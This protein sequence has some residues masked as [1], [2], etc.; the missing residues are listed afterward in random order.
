MHFF[1]KVCVAMI[2]RRCYLKTTLSN[3]AIVYG[4]NRS[5]YGGRGV[6]IFRDSIEPEFQHLE[7]FL[8]SSGVFIDVGASTGIYSLKAAKH[9][10]NIGIVI[11]IEPFPEVFATLYKSVVT[12]G[13]KNVRLRNL[14][15]W[16][17]TGLRTLWKNAH[18]PNSFSIVHRENNAEGISTL[19]VSLD[20]LVRWE[21]LERLDYLKIDAEGAE[22]EILAGAKNIIE[23]FRPIIQVEIQIQEC[24]V[25]CPDYSGFHAPGSI[26]TVYI[27]NL[28]FHV[29]Y[30]F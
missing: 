12:N 2:P 24:H 17:E 23:R 25:E 5:G 4:I 8:D 14:S 22:Q 27:P 10:Q 6:Y 13:F 28:K 1:R 20:D 18:K 3:K 19:T 26:N 21:K 16:S 29:N 9:Y 11:A 15:V 30:S 7:R